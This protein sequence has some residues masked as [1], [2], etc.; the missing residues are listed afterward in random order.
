MKF[1]VGEN[2]E[3]LVSNGDI[4]SVT[5]ANQE[6]IFQLNMDDLPKGE[7]ITVYFCFKIVMDG[8]ITIIDNY[9]TIHKRC[10]FPIGNFPA[11]IGLNGAGFLRNVFFFPGNYLIETKYVISENYV[12]ETNTTTLNFTNTTT[13][14]FTVAPSGKCYQ[15]I[16]RLQKLHS[17]LLTTIAFSD[18]MSVS[19]IYDM[20]TPDKNFYTDG[21]WRHLAKIRLTDDSTYLAS[22]FSTIF[23]DLYK[24]EKYL[25]IYY[26]PDKLL[27]MRQNWEASYNFFPK[28]EIA[29]KRF[30]N[31]GFFIIHIEKVLN[32]LIYKFQNMS[33]AHCLIIT[34]QALSSFFPGI[35]LI[36]SEMEN[37]DK[38]KMQ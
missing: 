7:S 8:S 25:T 4:I 11:R 24:L 22:H 30:L 3:R 12:I 31:T 19:E 10:D 20:L 14:N 36:P 32:E 21:F 16:P 37:W 27:D 38:P 35:T 15:K 34:N 23:Y 33:A 1:F 29:R 18:N 9:F 17:D 5:E 2:G 13:L 28:F 6:R 26:S